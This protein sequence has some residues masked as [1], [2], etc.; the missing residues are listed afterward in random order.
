MKFKH[1]KLRDERDST[2]RI[3]AKSK[4]P[5]LTW[6]ESLPS[7]A[8]IALIALIVLIAFLLLAR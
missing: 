6:R 5:K 8:L 7:L 3:S 2:L 4:E 1:G